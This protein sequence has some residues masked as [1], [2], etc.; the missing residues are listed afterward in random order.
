MRSVFL[1]A[2]TQYEAIVLLAIGPTKQAG[3]GLTRLD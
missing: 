2:A 1:S 3:G